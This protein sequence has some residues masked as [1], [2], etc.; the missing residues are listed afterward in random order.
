[1][2]RAP[3]LLAMVLLPPLRLMLMLTLA[4]M[5]V[6]TPMPLHLLTL[7]PMLMLMLPALTPIL[8]LALLRGQ[9]RC[10]ARQSQSAAD[11]TQPLLPATLRCQVGRGSKPCPH[12][13]I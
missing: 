6:L 11:S 2:P 4:P 1:V 8:L 10:G 13:L 9:P 12:F 7:T 5:L 3:L